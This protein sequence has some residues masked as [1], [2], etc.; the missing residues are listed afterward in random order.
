MMFQGLSKKIG[1]RLIDIESRLEG[2]ELDASMGEVYDKEKEAMRRVMF[3]DSFYLVRF[4]E[5]LTECLKKT[6]HTLPYI[7]R[8]QYR[9]AG[10][11]Y[12]AT[13]TCPAQAVVSSLSSMPEFEHYYRDVVK[14]II[15]PLLKRHGLYSP[16]IVYMIMMDLYMYMLSDYNGYHLRDIARVFL[17]SYV[18]DQTPE[19]IDAI[20]WLPCTT[21]QMMKEE[22]AVWKSFKDIHKKR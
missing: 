13:A 15:A 7:L 18:T 19:N 12:A 2:A 1:L 6:H 21:R 8:N 5:I 14:Y 20:M 22:L 4:A 3:K 17:Q 9:N 10:T 11:I 16:N